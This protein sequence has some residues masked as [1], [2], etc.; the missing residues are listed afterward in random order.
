MSTESEI[1][2]AWEEAQRLA[3]QVAQ[4]RD[5]L[6][7]QHPNMKIGAL[8]GMCPS[9]EAY[10]EADAKWHALAHG[11]SPWRVDVSPTRPIS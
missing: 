10:S 6:K 8:N 9:W 2:A 5:E 3:K 7:K 1:D 4:E 11:N